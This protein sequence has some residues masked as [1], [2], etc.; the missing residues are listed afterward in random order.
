VREPR[1]VEERQ[2]FRSW[3]QPARPAAAEDLPT[4]TEQRP[5]RR[6]TLVP[7]RLREK[8][9]LCAPGAEDPVILDRYRL[10]RTRVL[11]HMRASGRRSLGI[12]SAVAGAGKTLTTINLAMSIARDQANTVIV[13]DA[14]LRKPSTAQDLGI[15]VE[16]GLIDFL[17]VEMP[18]DDVLVCPG[19]ENLLIL[20]GR[21]E[22]PA[23]VTPELLSHERMDRLVAALRARKDAIVIVD[24]PPI[25][26]GDDVVAFAPQLDSLLLVVDEGGTD[27][28]SLKRAMELVQNVN[29]LGVVLN[30]SDDNSGG[31]EG[32]Y[33][34][35]AGAGA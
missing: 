20:P 6:V 27:V 34:Y 35:G 28:T 17:S 8:H 24:L 25:L 29:I 32:Y 13:V 4:A 12:T 16:K 9:F 23:K 10:L 5:V 3:T 30:K 22:D 15:P 7:A 21:R 11:Q 31:G 2:T 1:T 18:L 26:V 19:I 14:D 33:H